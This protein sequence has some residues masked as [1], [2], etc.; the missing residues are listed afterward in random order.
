MNFLL[1]HCLDETAAMSPDDD[2]DVSGSLAARE[3]GAWDAEM[4]A[5]GGLAAGNHDAQALIRAT[6]SPGQLELL[7]AGAV[8]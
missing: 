6:A 5:S 7:L 4:E 8:L 1:I 2:S 3:Q